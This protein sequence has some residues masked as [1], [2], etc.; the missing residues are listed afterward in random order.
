MGLE[1]G[2]VSAAPPGAGLR[3]SPKVAREL[4]KSPYWR[5]GPIP[6]ASPHA[7]KFAPRIG[8]RP[9]PPVVYEAAEVCPWKVKPEHNSLQ[10][11]NIVT[12]HL[13]SGKS[14]YGMRMIEKYVRAGKFVMCNFDLVGPWWS[15]FVD[16]TYSKKELYRVRSRGSSDAFDRER[17]Q[18][19]RYILRHVWRFEDQSE[20]FDYVLPG[21]PAQED[22][23][24]LVVDEAGLRNNS[25]TRKLREGKARDATGDENAEIEWFVHMRKLGWTCLMLTQDAGMVDKQLLGVTSSEVHLVNFAKVKIPFVGIPLARKPSFL[26]KYFW[27]EGVKKG[28]PIAR[29]YYGLELAIARHYKSHSRFSHREKQQSSGLR[30]QYDY[31]AALVGQPVAF[32]PQTPVVELV[33]TPSLGGFD[34]APDDARGVRSEGRAERDEEEE[35]AGYETPDGE[36]EELP[37]WA[38]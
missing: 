24:L 25:R 21:D 20:L 23:G 4:R 32:D 7:G 38:S 1:P 29:E 17:Y 11:I 37:P 3:L 15:T 35:G 5:E 34:P 9:V 10:A 30:M 33:T 18:R 31:D 14:Y 26:A 12:G 2:A 19:M 8:P 13:G 6:Q 36:A 27:Q 16:R 22:R 28:K